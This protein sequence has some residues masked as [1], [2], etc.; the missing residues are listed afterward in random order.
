M[1]MI[2]QSPVLVLNKI[3]ANPIA[4]VVR[5]VGD[6]LIRAL[7]YNAQPIKV[8]G[9]HSRLFYKMGRN[10]TLNYNNIKQWPKIHLEVH[11][12]QVT[13]NSI[14][15]SFE[16]NTNTSYIRFGLLA[17]LISDNGKQF[18]SQNF[19]EFCSSLGIK[20]RFMS[21]ELPQSYGQVELANRI[22]LRGLK[23]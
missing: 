10:R 1:P 6:R 15:I 19:M 16:P 5:L 18:N 8:C 13:R 20:Q 3:D 12:M 17:T 21:V 4:L 14:L 9:G 22:L 7:P 2:H 23:K 11:H